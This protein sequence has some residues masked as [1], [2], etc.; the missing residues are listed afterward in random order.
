MVIA[1]RGWFDVAEVATDALDHLVADR[2]APIVGAI[3]P[4][5]FF[6]FTQE[7]PTTELDDDGN[8]RTRWPENEL[9]VLAALPRRRRPRPRR[10]R[11]RRAA[12]ALRDVRR[13]HRHASRRRSPSRSS[14]PSAPAPRPCRTPACRWSSAARTNA[15]LAGALGLSRPQYQGIT[16]LVGVLQERLDRA[17]IPA[18]LAAR[19]RAPLPRQRPA[20]A[21]VDR[22]AAPPRARARRADRPRRPGRG[23]DA[24]ADRCTTRPSPR[25]RRP[26]PTCRCSSASTT[27]GRGRAAHR[28]RPRRRVRAL[29]PRAARRP[30]IQA[31]PNPSTARAI[32]RSV[33][34]GQPPIA[35]RRD[36]EAITSVLDA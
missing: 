35:D 24:L 33:P 3:D 22:P 15:G 30:K 20:P 36:P 31:P 13:V 19:R 23:G 4:D 21:V 7:R 8:R 34:F 12:P 17:G 32:R 9:R 26:P 27:A 11:R 16:G 6:D 14:S 28:R 2:V 5:P 1:L 10:A 25:T 29:P 18:D